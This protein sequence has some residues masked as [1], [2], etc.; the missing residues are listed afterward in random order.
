MRAIKI[1]LKEIYNY[2]MKVLADTSNPFDN[3]LLSIRDAMEWLVKFASQEQNYV[4]A[5]S[6][7]STA[8]D[9][10]DSGFS[11]D[12]ISGAWKFR[13]DNSMFPEQLFVRLRGLALSVE[14]EDQRAIFQALTR[15]PP[16]GE[17][18]YFDAGADTELDQTRVP[19]VRIG[20]VQRQDSVR[21]PDVVGTVSLQNV[22]PIGEWD[23]A[24]TAGA[25]RSVV[26]IKGGVVSGC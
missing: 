25:V 9:A 17:V 22:S 1:G 2:E 6:V 3:A 21:A 14:T 4:L 8:G 5:V 19:P 16:R 24:V 23:V 15:V 26:G 20:R 13:L 10:W 11:D 18:H 12:K 7:K